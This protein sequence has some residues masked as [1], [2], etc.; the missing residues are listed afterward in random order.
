MMRGMKIT[1]AL[2]AEH[3]IFL[4]VFDQIVRALP[5]FTTPAEVSTMARIVEGLLAG[6]A[7]TET[8]LAYLALDHVLA[9][10]G[11]SRGEFP[12]VYAEGP[13]KVD[14]GKGHLVRQGTDLTIAACGLMTGV[15]LDAAAILAD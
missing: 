15:A 1:E 11:A 3:K 7:E 6:H 9:D 14:V 12:Q 13:C 2:V 4:S 10:N 5:S 8:N